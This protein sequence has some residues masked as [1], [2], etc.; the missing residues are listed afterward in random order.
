MWTELLLAVALGSPLVEPTLE[1]DTLV[2]VPD[3][4]S[5][6]VGMR[7]SLPAGRL[8]PWWWSA[9]ASA[10]WHLPLA[11]PDLTR[12]IDAL[13]SFHLKSDDWNTTLSAQFRARDFDDAIATLSEF[14]TGGPIGR[15]TLRAWR[16]A[17]RGPWQTPQHTLSVMLK[18][19]LLDPRDLRRQ[20]APGPPR[21]L[22]RLQQTR[23]A[24]LSL[25]DRIIGFTGDV[26]ID[27]A[28]AS[29][30]TLLPPHAASLPAGITAKPIPIPPVAGGVRTGWLPGG[31]Q[32]AVVLA[33]SS[34]AKTD[35]DYPALQVALHALA[36]GIRSRL[37]LALRHESGLIYS[38]S[39]D[40]GAGA[41]PG[42]LTVT[43]PAR[44]SQLSQTTA[45]A[46]RLLSD[47]A[48]QGITPSE[49][50]A[51]VR[52]LRRSTIPTTPDD[53]LL[54]TMEALRHDW[55][56]DHSIT[57]IDTA[58]SMPLATI[59]TFIA[60]FFSPEVV[61]LLRVLPASGLPPPPP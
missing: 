22:T 17:G 12:R 24:L 60:D 28:R 46:E 44:A 33:R 26:S 19:M 50:T 29:V 20:P 52:A 2:V 1:G 9:D 43:I 36:G 10:A 56:L 30:A 8:S 11:S 40:D 4:R 39:A 38:L 49:H 16:S 15:D 61:A 25:R 53:V 31:G 23:T 34:M 41:I 5:A 58:E 35:P 27:Q 18:R 47:F 37:L 45:H 32:G 57:R 55:P 6:L 42:L 3:T 7:L 54:A 48:A 13:M 59:N 14:L 51:A 21:G